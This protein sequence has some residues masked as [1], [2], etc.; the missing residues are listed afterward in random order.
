MSP[1]AQT[2]KSVRDFLFAMIERAELAESR[3]GLVY[4][5]ITTE[6]ADNQN[7]IPING[8]HSP[9]GDIMHVDEGGPTHL[10][11]EPTELIEHCKQLLLQF[12][13]LQDAR[14]LH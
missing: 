2:R 13:E 10:M 7:E 4:L 5:Q 1:K 3:E 6:A 9:I 14:T 11:V 12:P 8:I